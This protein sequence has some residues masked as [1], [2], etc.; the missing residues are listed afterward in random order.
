MKC[1]FFIFSF[2][3]CHVLLLADTHVYAAGDALLPPH[4]Q[5]VGIKH[6]G[7]FFFWTLECH[8]NNDVT[9]VFKDIL[10]ILHVND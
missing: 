7:V 10:T 8:N 5:V 6:A 3:H 9:F 1:F 2:W 4:M